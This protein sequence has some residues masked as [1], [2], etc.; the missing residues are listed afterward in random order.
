MICAA[1]QMTGDLV[2]T[3]QIEN[4]F[5]SKYKIIKFENALL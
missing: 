4:V 1:S 5:I 2:L 3:F